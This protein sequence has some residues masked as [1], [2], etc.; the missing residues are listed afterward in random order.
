MHTKGKVLRRNAKFLKERDL[1]FVVCLERCI[2]R[3]GIAPAALYAD[4]SDTQI[5]LGP[6]KAVA[7]I[8]ILTEE[9][10]GSL[11]HGPQGSGESDEEFL[12]ALQIILTRIGVRLQPPVIFEDDETRLQ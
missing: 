2:G 9:L 1:D 5:L 6:A 10:V 8:S 3:S 11:I 7:I 4:I 12:H